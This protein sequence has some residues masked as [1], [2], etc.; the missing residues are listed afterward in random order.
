MSYKP[1]TFEPIAVVG[2]ACRF[3]GKSSSPAKLWELLREPHDLSKRVP[4]TRFNITGFYNPDGEYHGTTNAPKSYWLEEDHRTF[5]AQ[6]FNITPKEAE[7]IDPQQKILLEVCYEAV[8]SAG[9]SMSKLSG[10]KVSCYVG[11]MTADFDGMTQ[12]DELTSSQYCATG[13]S[14]A[15]IS[16]RISYFFNWNGPSM[17]IDTACSSSLVAVHQAVLSLR[18]NESTVACVAGANVMISPE[19]FIAEASLHMLSPTGK[20]RMWDEGA[21][22]YA[23]GEGIAA[24]MLKTL[25]QALRDGD[26]IE[27]II[28]ESGVNSD[29]RTQG[30]TMPSSVAQAALITDTYRRSGLDPRDSLDRCQYF[31]A[32]GTGT[33]AGDPRE[34]GAIYRAFFGTPEDQLDNDL[35]QT[36]LVGSIKTVIGHTEGAAGLAG[37]I[38]CLQSLHHQIIPP[39]QHLV[40]INP[41]V[42][43]FTRHLRVPTKLTPWPSVSKGHPLRA[44][45]N[46][47]GFGGT[48]AH[49]ILERYE[50]TIHLPVAGVDASYHRSEQSMDSG[51]NFSLPLLLSANSEASLSMMVRDFAKYLQKSNASDVRNLA[52]T[53]AQRRTLFPHR[54]A[55]CGASLAALQ[56][57]VQAKIQPAN[58]DQQSDVGVRYKVRGSQPRILG[59]FTGQGAQWPQMAAC[60]IST[61]PQFHTILSKLDRVLQN[62]PDPPS[63]SLI[64][65]LKAPASTSRV[66][67]AEISQPACTAIQIALVDVLAAVGVTFSGVVGHSSGEIGA[68]YAAGILSAESAILIAYYRGFHAKLA[69]GGEQGSMLAAGLDVDSA[70]DLCEQPTL[71]GRLCVAA[72]NSPAGVTL[73]GDKDAVEEAKSILDAKKTFARQLKVDTAYHSHHMDPCAAPYLAS[74]AKLDIAINDPSEV[75]WT[76]SVYGPAGTPSKEELKGRYFRDNMV[77]AVL[78]SEALQRAL[79]EN[80]PFD[81]AVEV[82]PHPALKGPAIQTMQEAIGSAMPYTGVLSRGKDDTEAFKDCLGFLW[83]Y[84]GSAAVK[85]DRFDHLFAAAELPYHVVKGLPSY[86]WDHSKI[87]LRQSRLARQYLQKSDLPHELLG[88]RTPDDSE[89]EMRWRNV[90]KPVDLPWL[91]HHRFQGQIIVPAAA[92]CIMALDAGRVLASSAGPLRMVELEDLH[93]TSGISIEDDSQGAEVMFTLKPDSEIVQSDGSKILEA[94]FLITSVAVDGSLGVKKAV[95]GRIKITTGRPSVACL[96]MRPAAPAG[97]HPVKIQ[98][99]YDQMEQIG[100]GYSGPFRALLAIERKSDVSSAVMMRHSPE[101]TSQLAVRPALL[102]VC[103]QAAFAAFAAPGDGALWT[104]FLP[105]SIRKLRFNLAICDANSAPDASQLGIDAYVTEFQP[106]TVHRQASFTGDIEVFNLQDQMLIQIEGITVASFAASTEAE[107]REL[108][109]R[110]KWLNDPVSGFI[111]TKDTFAKDALPTLVDSLISLYVPDGWGVD[112]P[113]SGE[114]RSS[115]PRNVSPAMQQTINQLAVT[116]P[117][118][119]TLG[120]IRS[121]GENMPSM[122]PSLRQELIQEAYRQARCSQLTSN[123]MHQI[124]HRF[125]RTNI[126][127]VAGESTVLPGIMHGL[128]GAFSKYEFATAGISVPEYFESL[129]SRLKGNLST[130]VVDPGQDLCQQGFENQP[131]D[132]IILSHCIHRFKSSEKLLADARE[133]IKPGG[134]LVVLQSI[135]AQLHHKLARSFYSADLSSV[136]SALCDV[137]QIIDSTWSHR[138]LDVDGPSSEFSIDVFQAVDP[139]MQSLLNPLNHI[140]Q[141]RITGSVVLIGGCSPETQRITERVEGVLKPFDCAI[142][143]YLSLEDVDLDVA[144]TASAVL[145]TSDLDEPILQHMNSNTLKAL[146]LLFNPHRYILWLV[147]D[148]REGQPWHFASVGMGRSLKAETPQLDLQFLDLDCQPGVED[149]VVEAL[150]RLAITHNNSIENTHLWTT[151]HELVIREKDL[152][153]PRIVPL[154]AQND[155]LNSIRRVIHREVADRETALQLANT[156]NQGHHRF[157]LEPASS[158]AVV[159]KNTADSVTIAVQYS[160]SAAIVIKGSTRLFLVAG[161]K[162]EDGTRVLALSLTNCSRINAS[163]D[164][165]IPAPASGDMVKQLYLFTMYLMASRIEE[166][167]AERLIALNDAPEALLLVLAA[168]AKVRKSNIAVLSASKTNSIPE[169]QHIH[170][171]PQSAVRVVQAAMPNA[172]IFVLDFSGGQSAVSPIIEASAHPGSVFLQT[173]CLYQS[174]AMATASTA[175]LAQT[176]R[177]LTTQARKC[178]IIHRLSKMD[179]LFTTI[180]D[181]VAVDHVAGIRIVDWTDLQRLRQVQQPLDPKTLFSSTK[182]YILI[183]LTGE[184]GQSLAKMMV[185]NGARH[186][187]VASRKPPKQAQWRDDLEAMGADVRIEA[188]DA[189]DTEAV[190][191]LRDVLAHTMPPVGGILNGAMILADGL[192]ADMSIENYW[193]V[194]HPK[195]SGSKVLDEVFSDAALDFFVMFSSLTAVAGN[196]GQSNYAAANMVSIRCTP[197]ILPLAD[198]S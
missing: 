58:A 31:E 69:G 59:I 165:V 62:C 175:D 186:L 37:L 141:S 24:V 115:Q 194:L 72:S 125:P 167:A 66:H 105:Q 145:I 53:M 10:S 45:V 103:F 155:R 171:H 15:I 169:L 61:S 128:A 154:L 22:G 170:I 108:Y 139:V 100:L 195:A 71:K 60:L 138:A 14:R 39:N 93:I 178:H 94:A 81:V 132:I 17:T 30:I 83:T 197:E 6:F 133:L 87:Y 185:V 119:H 163:K 140:E 67:Q 92:Y 40:K 113:G 143:T 1:P 42:E 191:G 77:Q 164:W 21:D 162:I 180:T 173:D 52:W 49:V 74:L 2:S 196:R 73:S 34:A 54:V 102:D 179:N 26:H 134:F 91:K 101:D 50:P 107:D 135:E 13:T 176:L 48:N 25:S 19:N 3:P 86:P 121:F 144:S 11:T 43:P 168:S 85:F 78:F 127:E 181:L 95:D 111:V 12:R 96:P 182:T 64:T 20:S 131:F 76:S 137:S 18:N 5:D 130:R 16:N 156:P 152:L 118:Q 68:A 192:F 63:W 123:V 149:R 79:Q 129:S 106:T 38:K 117:H 98:K 146:Q 32:H 190:T 148:F 9:L 136:Q 198:D 120:L 183:G 109:L 150:L 27:G 82:G 172:Q 153:I 47:F 147:R 23:R 184:L 158:V 97:M 189:T 35:G 161:T 36:M 110:T 8:E 70:I 7:A 151:E 122:L 4:L 56:N 159:P 124:S 75:S 84:L 193:K 114:A 46:S 29:G 33:Q 157:S 28:R 188:V 174:C 44:S 80:G 187:V 57:S 99:F 90:L 126:L 55:F 177:S 89:H 166:L 112:P 160:T 88:I 51:S 142:H 104:S 65:E 41:A 116:S